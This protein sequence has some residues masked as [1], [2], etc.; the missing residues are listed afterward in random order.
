MPVQPTP[1][2]I[3]LSLF[4]LGLI[5]TIIAAWFW[6]IWRIASGRGLLPPAPIRVVPWKGLHVVGMILLYLGVQMAVPILLLVLGIISPVRR[7]GGGIDVRT[8][9]QAMIAVNA[10]F[11][12][13]GPTALVFWTKAGPSDFGLE[14]G[15]VGWDVLRGIVAWPLLSPIVYLVQVL[16]MR[17][18]S[19][20]Q[21]PL[22][23]WIAGDPNSLNWG[24]AALSAA[25]LA[26]AVE[27]FLFRGVLLGWLGRWASGLR[28]A[29]PSLA[30]DPDFGPLAAPEPVVWFEATAG[31]D[32][33]GSEE[34]ADWVA[35]EAPPPKPA[36]LAARGWRF[37]AANV[38][39]SLLFAAM[40]GHVW[41]S[42]LPLFFLSLGLGVLYQRTGGLAAP[43]A[44]HA[45][46]NGLS[47]FLLY[48][49]MQ[50][51]GL[52]AL[53]PPAPPEAEPAAPK[54][55]GTPRDADGLQHPRPVRI[56]T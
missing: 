21:H 15:R 38:L 50:A 1:A 11:L 12:L 17:V 23:E 39:V 40:H 37:L 5:S 31:A 28:R 34:P 51:G 54:A 14:R 26:P 29:G 46:F 10:V 13:V 30:A 18:W 45:T 19:P 25:V 4:V 55:S 22:M 3:A 2:Q 33:P 52:D 56:R 41:P 27:E 35:A 43:V 24:L 48:L 44:L 49:S 6:A 53:K 20:R 42:P 7:P 9:N 32:A 8:Q 16:A 47:T 36:P